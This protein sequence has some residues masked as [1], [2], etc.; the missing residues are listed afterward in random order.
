MI[1]NSK[2]VLVISFILGA[3][4]GSAVGV[5]DNS[6]GWGLKVF[7]IVFFL[8]ILISYIRKNLGSDY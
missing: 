4:V 7:A 3:V 2:E 5:L 1:P 8:G 6:I